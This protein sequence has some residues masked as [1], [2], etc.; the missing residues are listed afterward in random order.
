MVKEEV[1]LPSNAP[2]LHLKGMRLAIMQPY[3]FPYIG[4][5]QLV[6]A[7][8][9]FVVYDDVSFIK[10]GW[11]NRNNILL[12]GARHLFSLPLEQATS[13]RKISETRIA[14]RLYGQWLAKFEKILSSSYK[15]APFFDEIFP[16]VINIL[17]EGKNAA[18]IA[19]LCVQGIVAIKEFLGIDTVLER[20]ST[21]YGNEH[22]S[23][24]ARVIDICKREKASVYINPIGGTELYSKE[25]FSKESLGLLFLK[26]ETIQYPQFRHEFVPHLSVIDCLMFNSRA[27]MKELLN[28]Y[29]LI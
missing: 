29:I 27:Q 23:A 12:N 15:K 4:Y 14:E 22:L 10:Q 26:T 2:A 7:A 9:K 21:V 24:A 16:L 3:L 28:Q 17:Q 19:E 25:E 6:N 11:I 20:T 8:D 18:S 1:V 5:F 13:F